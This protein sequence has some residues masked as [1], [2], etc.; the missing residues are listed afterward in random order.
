MNLRTLFLKTKKLSHFL[1][2]KSD[3]IDSVIVNRK[4]EFLKKLLCVWKRGVLYIS[5]R[6]QGVSSR[7]QA[8]EIRRIFIF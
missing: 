4:K 7:N 8:E 5:S 3:L 2:G 6:V 1:R